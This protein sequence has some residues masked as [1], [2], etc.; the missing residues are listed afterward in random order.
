[1]VID[2]RKEQK[3]IMELEFKEKIDKRHLIKSLLALDFR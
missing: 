3:V 2:K 1:M